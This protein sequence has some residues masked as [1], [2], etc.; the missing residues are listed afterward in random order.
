MNPLTFKQNLKYLRERA[1]LTQEGMARALGVT[2]A[3]L[4]SYEEGRAYPN[5]PKLVA[6][7]DRIGIKDVRTLLTGD[8]HALVQESGQWALEVTRIV[9][10]ITVLGRRKGPQAAQAAPIAHNCASIY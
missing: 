1:A 2:P 10:K 5:V 6:L 7:C 3:A 9:Q 4:G 8:M